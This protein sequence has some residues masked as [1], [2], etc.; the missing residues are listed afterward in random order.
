M[1]KTTKQRATL[2]D[3][4]T[5]APDEDSTASSLTDTRAAMDRLFAVASKSFESMT[6]GNS[7]EFL[8]RSR[9]TGGQ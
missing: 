5:K 8:R 2:H 1:N 3:I 6:E 9:Q 7:R 4:E